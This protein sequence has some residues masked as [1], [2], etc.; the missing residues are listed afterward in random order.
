MTCIS[1]AADRRDRYSSSI[2]SILWD[3]VTLVTSRG[4]CWLDTVHVTASQ[5]L[6]S[7]HVWTGNCRPEQ[8]N[9]TIGLC[10]SSITN[11]TV[12]WWN[13]RM[14]F[15]VNIIPHLT[16]NL[17]ILPIKATNSN[18]RFVKIVSKRNRHSLPYGT[19]QIRLLY[20][21]IIICFCHS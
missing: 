12:Y 18:R 21:Y 3:D 1:H 4:H 19:L 2:H 17:H 20:V 9:Q 6:P 11:C 14:N 16:C 10:Q 15:C 8:N 13:K 5:L 7:I